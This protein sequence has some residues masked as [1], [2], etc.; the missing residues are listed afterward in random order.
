MNWHQG[1]C[2]VSA[3]FWGFWAALFSG[4]L[5]WSMFEDGNSMRPTLSL[6]LF[7]CLAGGYACYRLTNWIIGGFFGK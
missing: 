6:Y 2:R 4:I 5:I 7:L 1:F 3:V